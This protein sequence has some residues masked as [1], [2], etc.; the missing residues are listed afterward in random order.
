[1]SFSDYAFSQTMMA[2]LTQPGSDSMHLWALQPYLLL[3]RTQR[4]H[5]QLDRKQ[6]NGVSISVD[7]LYSS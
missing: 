7:D 5:Q 3:D 4:H 6:L 1:M 2:D